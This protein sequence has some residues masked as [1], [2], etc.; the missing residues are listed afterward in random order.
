M[1]FAQNLKELRKK[2]HLSQDALAMKLNVSQQAVGKWETE[3]SFPDFKML[4]Q[5]ADFFH[6][7]IDYLLGHEVAQPDPPADTSEPA[8]IKELIAKELPNMDA[9]DAAMV[10]QFVQF[11]KVQKGLGAKTANGKV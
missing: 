8:D 11:L 1:L 7:S 9:E 5:L 3:K 10:G 4:I 6:V 2:H